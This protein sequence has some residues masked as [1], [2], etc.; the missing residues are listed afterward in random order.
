MTE[1]RILRLGYQGDGI[2]EGPVFAPRTL[3]GE[4]VEG[5]KVGDRIAAPR[6]VTPSADRVAAPCQHYKVC[7]GCALQHASDSF[8]AEWRQDVVRRALAAQGIDAPIRA[9]HTSPP[10][11][12]RRATFSVKRTKSGAMV[13]FHAPSSDILVDTPECLLVHPAILAARPA[14]EELAGVGASRK[15]EVKAAVTDSAAGLDVAITGG[16][17]LYGPLRVELGGV[18]QRHG[19][20]RLS[21]DGE[22]V[23]MAAPP[24]QPMGH[25]KVAP[26]PGAF[27]Q[28]TAEGEAALVAAMR[29]AVGDAAHVADLFC[30]CG[31]FA[32]PLAERAEVHAVES[33]PEMLGALDQGWRYATGL[34]KVTTE[35]RDL[36]R[37]PLLAEELARFDA[38]VLDPPRAGAEAQT[39]EVAKASPSR[40]GFVSC[41]PVTFARDAAVLVDA[42]LTLDWIEVVDQFRWS[43][44]VELAA[45]FTRSA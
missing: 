18:A 22:T 6:I 15:A 9:M 7:G 30:G 14:L 33:A 26:P 17:P 29:A 5:E 40:V 43:P 32:L 13:G 28:A 42:G 35:A 4:V 27:L 34:K 3:P 2:A 8:V 1:H 31:T 16:K 11:S 37:N 10:R 12:R 21:W 19:L 20:A 38:I 41:N 45:G 24:V 25:G 23:A 39:R 36:F 44:H